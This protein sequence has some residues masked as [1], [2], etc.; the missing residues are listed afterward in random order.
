MRKLFDLDDN[1]SISLLS[2]PLGVCGGSFVRF[3]FDVITSLLLL[4]LLLLIIGIL[5]IP[6]IFHSLG[7]VRLTAMY[8]SKSR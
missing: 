3:V 5:G 1:V 4:L 8:C 2:L 6:V 7:I